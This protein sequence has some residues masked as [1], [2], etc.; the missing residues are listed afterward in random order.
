MKLLN[1]SLG[2]VQQLWQSTDKMYQTIRIACKVIAMLMAS[3]TITGNV[4]VCHVIVRLK[5]MKTSINYI[6]LNLAIIDTISGVFVIPF[7]FLFDTHGTF[8]EPVLSQAFNHSSTLADAICKVQW[9][10]WLPFNV[11]P[12]ILMLMAYE[13]FK[14]VT[15]PLSRHDGSVTKARLKWMLP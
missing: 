12:L 9:I 15:D 6:I 4:L 5:T 14:A 10:A 2:I 8:G 1:S 11:S 3:I 7:V 13:R